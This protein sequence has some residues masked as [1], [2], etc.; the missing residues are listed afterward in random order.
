MSIVLSNKTT[1]YSTIIAKISKRV[2]NTS[3]EV[4]DAQNRLYT[5][6]SDG[7]YSVGQ[8]VRIQNNIIIAKTTADKNT[9]HFMV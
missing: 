4:I 1:T 8:T 3:F 5:V 2:S 6:E 9:K 7:T